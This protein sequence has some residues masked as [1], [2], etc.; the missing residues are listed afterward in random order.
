MQQNG[1]RPRLIA[2][3]RTHLQA[4]LLPLL[5]QLR[6]GCLSGPALILELE[7]GS[8]ILDFSHGHSR[9]VNWKKD[10]KNLKKLTTVL[11]VAWDPAG[12]L[13]PFPAQTIFSYMILASPKLTPAVIQITPHGIPRTII[14]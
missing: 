9:Q 5:P 6:V 2:L 10:S 3:R 11:Q 13:I 7:D 1:D 8:P 12:D 14:M 4:T